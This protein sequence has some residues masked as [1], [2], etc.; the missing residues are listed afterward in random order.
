[1]PMQLSVVATVSAASMIA[2]LG[3]NIYNREH[4]RRS[5]ILYSLSL[6]PSGQLRYRP[7]SC[8]ITDR[9]TTTCN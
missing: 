2:G 3:G 8:H 6:A 4:H 7:R 9:A 1:M 5:H